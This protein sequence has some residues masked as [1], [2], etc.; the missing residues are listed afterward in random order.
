MGVKFAPAGAT[1]GQVG[2][3]FYYD[4]A[5]QHYSWE[6]DA[7]TG[8]PDPYFGPLSEGGFVHVPAGIQ[9]FEFGGTASDCAGASWGWPGSVPNRIRLPVRDGYIA[10][11]SLFCY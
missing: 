1:V 2:D 8:T 9:E 11:G 6:L 3:P 4:T 10:Y 7:T 5:T